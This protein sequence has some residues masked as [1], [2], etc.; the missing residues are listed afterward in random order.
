MKNG[1][2]KWRVFVLDGRMQ[3]MLL[4]L[5]IFLILFSTKAFAIKVD[6]VNQ[7]EQLL[8]I[9]NEAITKLDFKKAFINLK[10]SCELGNSNACRLVINESG[11]VL[12][13]S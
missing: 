4:L 12:H 6:T 3:R 13:S 11:Y 5:S 1:V 8:K 2:R 7:A 10:K 9:G